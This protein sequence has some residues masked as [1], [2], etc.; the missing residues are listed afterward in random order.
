MEEIL[1]HE[2]KDVIATLGGLIKA[3]P[4]CAA[5][6]ASIAAYEGCEELNKM[7]AEY[8]A[9]QNL[10]SDLYAKNGEDEAA[11]DLRDT[12]QDRIDTLYNAITGHPVY[13][14]YVD[15]KNAFDAL[16]NEVYGELQFVITGKRPCA[17]DC[18]SCG[19]DCHHHH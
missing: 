5:I 8:N 15:A 9:Q 4:R 1:T 14:A 6:E 12:I 7:I 16:T 3:D 11:L 18:S 17:H 2:M 10:L 13:V 19:S